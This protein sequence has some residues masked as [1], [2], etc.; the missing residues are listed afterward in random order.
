MGI[1]SYAKDFMKVLKKPSEQ[2]RKPVNGIL[3]PPVRKQ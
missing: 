1:L 3:R 2:S